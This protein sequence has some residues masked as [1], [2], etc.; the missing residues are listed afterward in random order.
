MELN[1]NNVDLTNSVVTDV[2][3]GLPQTMTTQ[4]FE[5]AVKK[6]SDITR[7]YNEIIQEV[8]KQNPGLTLENN[9]DE[10]VGLASKLAEE[11]LMAL[12]ERKQ[13]EAEIAE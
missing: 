9:H 3:N 6:V 5:V 4:Q 13:E 8:L 1:E 10:V 7:F 11:K 12:D 2:I